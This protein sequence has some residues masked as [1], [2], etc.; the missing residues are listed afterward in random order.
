[1]VRWQTT[2]PFTV[3]NFQRCS[4][5][6]PILLEVDELEWLIQQCRI[7]AHMNDFLARLLH[8]LE[9]ARQV[10]SLTASLEL[11]LLT[12]TVD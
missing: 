11:A 2:F 5:L 12:S 8:R 10:R 6:T 3:E 1:V 4:M 7:H 9:E